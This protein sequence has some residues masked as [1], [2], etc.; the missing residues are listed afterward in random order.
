MELT[1]LQQELET[2]DSFIAEKQKLVKRGEQ[3]KELMGSEAFKAVILDGYVEEE[4]RKLFESLTNPMGVS[5][6]TEEE[7]LL[8]IKAINHFKGY[9]GTR[10]IP[11]S[12]AM[13]AVKAPIDIINEEDH[14]KQVTA[15][16]AED[17]E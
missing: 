5:A 14:R 15:K 6:Y 12:V 4:S 13:D 11:G 10:L 7:T 8:R 17:E 3:L 2:I 1:D 9:I 16:Y